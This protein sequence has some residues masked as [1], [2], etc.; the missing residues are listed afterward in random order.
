MDIPAREFSS[1]MGL[2]SL[3][4][5]LNEIWIPLYLGSLIAGVIFATL[6]YV[7][8]RI[9]WRINVI[10]HWNKRKA[11]RLARVNNPK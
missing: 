5:E 1:D 6:G 7:G 9:L 10:T 4:S 2:D 11:E 8:M 3:L